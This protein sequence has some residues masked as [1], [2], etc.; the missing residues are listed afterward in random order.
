M[1]LSGV[2]EVHT[3]TSPPLPCAPEYHTQFLVCSQAERNAWNVHHQHLHATANSGS[4]LTV[5]SQTSKAFSFSKETQQDLHI[6]VSDSLKCFTTQHYHLLTHH[7]PSSSSSLPSYTSLFHLMHEKAQETKRWTSMACP[8][9]DR[10][11]GVFPME[12]AENVQET[13]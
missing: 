1:H 6:H 8:E 5:S 4:H 3:K 13:E 2:N 7:I 11:G 9:K 10:Q 12:H